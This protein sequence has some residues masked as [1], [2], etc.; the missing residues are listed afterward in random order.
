MNLFDI[1]KN[2]LFLMFFTLI[3]GDNFFIANFNK[4][5]SK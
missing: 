3:F 2:T 5:C 1:G 4:L